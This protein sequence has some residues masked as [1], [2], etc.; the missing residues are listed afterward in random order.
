M[1]E[2]HS[3]IHERSIYLFIALTMR[4]RWASLNVLW[5]LDKDVYTVP[6]LKMSK[7]LSAMSFYTSY[8]GQH[9]PLWFLLHFMYLKIVFGLLKC[10]LHAFKI[11]KWIH[12]FQVYQCTK[13]VLAKDRLRKNEFL[14]EVLFERLWTWETVS[15]KVVSIKRNEIY[16]LQNCRMHEFT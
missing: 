2:R 13:K 9:L 14:T 7:S 1:D 11:W 5:D 4:C 8:F 3:L 10:I 16:L 12:V 15:I 6:I